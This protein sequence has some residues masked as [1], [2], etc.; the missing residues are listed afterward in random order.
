MKATATE[1]NSYVY[2]SWNMI[3]EVSHTPTPPSSQTN[4]YIWGLDL[5]QSLQGA[6]GVGALL[7]AVLDGEAYV[8]AFDANGNITEYA[9]TNGTIVAHYEYDPFGKVSA[10]SGDLADTFV[11]RFSTKYT[12]D[13]TGL[14]WYGY[15]YLNPELGR[16][17]N[18]DPLSDR[19]FLL[20]YSARRSENEE[21]HLHAESRKPSYSFADNAPNIKVDILGLAVNVCEGYKKYFGR[22][23]WFD[24]DPYPEDAYECCKA[25]YD[26][27]PPEDYDKLDCVAGCLIAAEKVCSKLPPIPK[28]T[29]WMCRTAAHEICYAK[30]KFIPKKLWPIIKCTPILL[31]PPGIPFM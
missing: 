9:D 19:S 5:S 20:A 4:S 2:D 16:W 1:T 12:D 26:L 11:Y 3:R 28:S 25:F 24:F 14:V 23:R 7:A 27:Y 8:P 31:P 21:S 13:E 10:Q 17:I 30:C 29:R 18:R 22:C 15:R 6:G